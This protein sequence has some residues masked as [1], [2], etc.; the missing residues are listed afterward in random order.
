MIIGFDFHNV[1]DAHPRTVQLLE[2]LSHG[3]N[4]IH[5]I[6][7]IGPRRIGTIENEVKKLTNYPVI[8]TEVVFKHPREAPL[9]KTQAAKA[10]RIEIFFDDRQDVCDE[11]NK[12]GILCFKVPRLSDLDDISADFTS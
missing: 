10:L 3:E 12:A 2:E 7:A 5:V 6:S 1:L 4:T 11:M 9:L 8:V